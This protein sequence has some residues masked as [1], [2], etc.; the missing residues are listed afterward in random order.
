[1]YG[2]KWAA[3]EI[4]F[5]AH[6]SHDVGWGNDIGSGNVDRAGVLWWDWFETQGKAGEEPPQWIKDVVDDRCGKVGC[7]GWF[8]EYNAQV[9]AAYKWC[10]DNLPYI[11]LVEHVKYPLVVNKNLKNVAI[12]GYAIATNFSMVQMWFDT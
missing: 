5:T 4:S 6:W 3:N 8:R 7:R 2:T 12:G 1:M 11:N 10:R 9:D